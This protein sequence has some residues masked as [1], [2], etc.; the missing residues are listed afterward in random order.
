LVG[1][2]DSGK[3][4]IIDAIRVFY[5][6][7]KFNAERDL[8][9]FKRGDEESWIEIKFILTDEEFNNLKDEYQQQING[10]KFFIVRKY[11]NHSTKVQSGSSNIYSYENGELSDNFFYGW[12]NVAQGKLGNILYIP[13]VSQIAEYTKLSGPSYLRNTL[14]FISKK[15]ISSGGSFQ[16]LNAAFTDFT[17]KFKQEKTKDGFSL[18]GFINDINSEIKDRKVKV[19]FSIRPL[20][21]ADIT[22]NLIEPYIK[23]E[24]LGDNKLPIESFGEGLQRRLVYTLIKL[25]TKY[26]EKK[27]AKDKKEFFSNFLLILFEEPEAFLHSSQQ[28]VLNQSLKE[29]S[30]EGSQQILISTH[31]VHF[32]SKNIDNLPSILKLYKQDGKTQVYQITKSGLRQT[33]VA[34]KQ[35]KNILGQQIESKDLELE[36]IRY[37]LWLDP[38][39]CC[40][41]FADFVLICEGASEKVLIDY[42]IKNKVIEMSNKEI[43]VINAM[44][45]ENIHR[46]MNL[47]KELGIKHSVLFDGD[48]NKKDQN[49]HQKVNEFLQSNKN[50]FTM[51]IDYFVDDLESFLNIPE[52]TRS[53]KKPLNVMWCYKNNKIQDTELNAFIGKIKQ[54]LL[55]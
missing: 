27:I 15:I 17:D 12:K 49:Y 1:A 8:P 39:R 20:D 46:Y 48:K 28:E 23:D 16:K 44:G 9:K 25:S 52:E 29:L 13:A 50:D 54:L 35:L 24:V 32:V 31:S 41:F 14:D 42:L 53:D 47:F 3:S 21:V 19:D 37:S 33:L 34:N 22:K 5:D 2:N 6:D 26:K 38:D 18:D 11:L 45:K 40:A 30:N 7:L 43:Y 4:N 36:A 10:E 51:L 55:F